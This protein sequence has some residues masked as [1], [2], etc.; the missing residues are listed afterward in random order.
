MAPTSNMP[1]LATNGHYKASIQ[2]QTNSRLQDITNTLPGP[3]A[4]EVTTISRYT[5]IFIILLLLFGEEWSE[6]N[7][8][9]LLS[10]NSGFSWLQLH[11]AT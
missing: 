2:S 7:H 3:S 11:A 4:S 8:Q 9:L 5:N 6:M 1:H 10:R